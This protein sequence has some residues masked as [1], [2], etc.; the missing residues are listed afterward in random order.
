MLSKLDLNLENMQ[1]AVLVGATSSS[2]DCNQRTRVFR[3]E[4]TLDEI[5]SLPSNL[6]YSRRIVRVHD[7]LHFDPDDLFNV[8]EIQIEQEKNSTL[9]GTHIAHF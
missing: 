5:S 3:V 7:V 6:K 9:G 4:M 8:A 1:S 2:T